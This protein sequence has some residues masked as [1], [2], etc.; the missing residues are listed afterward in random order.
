MSYD[1]PYIVEPTVEALRLS[2]LWDEALALLPAEA[3]GVRAHLATE[4][5]F[6]RLE[7]AAEAEEAVEALGRRDSALAG[8]YRAQL[9]YTRI[10]FLDPRPGDADRARRGISGATGHPRAADWAT[11]WQG[12]LAQHLDRDPE[13]AL[14]YF[15]KAL[16]ASRDRKDRL[17]ESYAIRHLGGDAVERGD[18]TGLDLLRRS[19]HL[20]S[21]L[22]ARP[23]T[24]AAA[25]T[26]AEA[27]PPGAEA[28]SLTETARAT[29]HD[30]GL[31]WLRTAL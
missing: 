31:T 25:A 1:T 5:F 29:A 19:Y 4:R 14:P 22:G 8:F 13:G 17:L 26:L 18:D 12:V 21:A 28:E 16:A 2:G 11:F 6:W 24:A 27:L 3:T 7:G 23:Q 15:R 10:I 20:R 9:A 30:L